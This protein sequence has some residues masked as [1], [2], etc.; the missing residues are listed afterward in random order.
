MSEL[1]TDYLGAGFSR[2][3]G[4]GSA[5]ALLLV[6]PVVAYLAPDSPL[7]CADRGRRS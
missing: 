5:P 6:D 2:R 7:Y 3:L 4:W 1:D